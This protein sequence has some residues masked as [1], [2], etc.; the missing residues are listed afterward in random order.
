MGR[1]IG[2]G[3]WLLER[4]NEGGRAGANVRGRPSIP[5][6]AAHSNRAMTQVRQEWNTPK[7]SL[8]LFPVPIIEDA[9]LPADIFG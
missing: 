1:S 6:S 8:E 5:V 7:E 3:T 2:L 9:R 4:A